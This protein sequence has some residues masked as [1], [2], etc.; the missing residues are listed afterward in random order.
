MMCP[1]IFI[2]SLD[3]VFFFNYMIGLLTLNHL[4][5][6]YVVTINLVPNGAASRGLI[7]LRYKHALNMYIAS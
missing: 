7:I 3:Q 5:I 1:C 6:I 4:T 2:L